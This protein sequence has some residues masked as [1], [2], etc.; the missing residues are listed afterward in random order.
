M[1]EV[2]E[3]KL[4]EQVA[5]RA[6]ALQRLRERNKPAQADHVPLPMN[7]RERRGRGFRGRAFTGQA[8]APRLPRYVRRHH[9]ELPPIQATTGAGPALT[10]R[11][12]KTFGRI[13]RAMLARGIYRV[14]A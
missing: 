8:P 2:D 14:A 13:G 5:Q 12:R 1:N 7:R 11:T 10:R 6:A 4:A 3:A 9:E